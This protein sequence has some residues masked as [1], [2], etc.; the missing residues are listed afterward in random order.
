MNYVSRIPATILA[1]LTRTVTRRG[2]FICA[3]CSLALVA[4]ASSATTDQQ[5][6]CAVA[7]YDTFSRSA[8][9]P[10]AGFN[11][12]FEGVATAIVGTEVATGTSR[13]DVKFV[14]NDIVQCK[15]TYVLPDGTLVLRSVCVL[16]QGH[17][18]WHVARGTGRYENFKA[19]GTETFGLLT[20]G[21]GQVFTN[22]E[23]FAGI[24]QFDKHRD[25]EHGGNH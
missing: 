22:F 8:A 23:R 16:S 7:I 3:L 4:S 18:T 21:P 1:V 17:G 5:P 10:P 2:V 11:V 24:G 9:T 19:V 20:V 13:M 12:S 6:I 25:D 15:F 14:T